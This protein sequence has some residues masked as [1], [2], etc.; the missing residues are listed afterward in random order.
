MH[1]HDTGRYLEPYT[2]SC[3]SPNLLR[4]SHMAGTTLFTQ[5]FSCAPTC[6][7]SRA[8]LLS[9]LYPHETAVNGLAHRGFSFAPKEKHLSSILKNSGYAAYLAGIQHEVPDWR[10]LG[11]DGYLGAAP[12][13][14]YSSASFDP[15]AWDREHTARVVDFIQNSSEGKQPFFLFWGLFNPHRPYPFAAG[16]ISDSAPVPEGLPNT[17]SIRRDMAAYQAGLLEADRNIGRVLDALEESGRLR[18][19]LLI[20]TTDHGIA[21]PG[22]KCTLTGRGTG[23]ALMVRL[24]DSVVEGS[25]PK[26]SQICDIPVSHLDIVPTI[27]ELIGERRDGPEEAGVNKGENKGDYERAG[28]RGVSLVP[29]LN[30]VGELQFFEERLLFSSISYHAAYEPYRAV[31]SRSFSYIKG[32]LPVELVLPNID[33]SLSKLELTENYPG[34][35]FLQPAPEQL[36]DLSADPHELNNAAADPLYADVRTRMAEEL[37]R[38]MR[39]TQDPLLQ[40]AVPAP[41]GA[42]IT[43]RNDYSPE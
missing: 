29:L 6:S 4:L 26:A 10:Q 22:H 5:A 9:G 23:A 13:A 14:P 27:L 3:R 16:D 21:F 42:V 30:G 35:P 11:Y 20:Y 12:E 19:T 40:G 17:N 36:Y 24:P 34:H 28:L 31:R 25:G 33:D 39:Q 15:E 8:A 7:P 1:T 37:E 41:D 2:A 43:S 32:A 38:W 18:D